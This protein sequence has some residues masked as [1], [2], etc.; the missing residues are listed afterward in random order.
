MALV[1]QE[2]WTSAITDPLSPPLHIPLAVQHI[3]DAGLGDDGIITLEPLVFVLPYEAGVVATFQG[4][5]MV[6]NS[7]QGVP[8]VEGENI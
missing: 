8:G 2:R 6:N 7:K 5:L 3:L 4:P 1:R